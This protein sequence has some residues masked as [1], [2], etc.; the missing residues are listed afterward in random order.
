MKG[1]FSIKMDAFGPL[2]LEA[3]V[4]E[5]YYNSL[6]VSPSNSQK[7]LTPLYPVI[8]NSEHHW[9]GA[10][11]QNPAAGLGAASPLHIFFIR[12]FLENV[13]GVKPHQTLRILNFT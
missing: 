4:K 7:G 1:L 3:H 13:V 2:F 11:L 5:V 8:G 10:G 6:R 9:A 12:T